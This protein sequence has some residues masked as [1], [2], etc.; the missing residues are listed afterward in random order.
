MHHEC[1]V[2]PSILGERAVRVEALE[3]ALGSVERERRMMLPPAA[4]V[5][6]HGQPFERAALS[7]K[8]VSPVS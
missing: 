4:F 7:R 6:A 2:E 8:R 5:L 3:D 1:R